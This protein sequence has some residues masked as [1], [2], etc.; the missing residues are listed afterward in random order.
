MEK[1]LAKQ[2]EEQIIKRDKIDDIV[3]GYRVE[4]EQ[5]YYSAQNK[6]KQWEE[7]KPLVEQEEEILQ[8]LLDEW[9]S[10]T[11][12]TWYKVDIEAQR[13]WKRDNEDFVEI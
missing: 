9:K 6:N 4:A 2:I 11:G 3:D 5:L 1:N 13:Q 8:K 10:V 7:S 12:S